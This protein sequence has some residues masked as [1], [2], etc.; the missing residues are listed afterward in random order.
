MKVIITGM[1]GTV[2]P[3]VADYFH[4]NNYQII[5]YDRTVVSTEN[6]K[7]IEAFILEHQPKFLLHFA[8][9]S[10]EWTKNLSM[11]CS[12]KQIKFVYI[13]TV[14]VFSNENRGPHTIDSIPDAED[15]YGRYK[16]MSES[17]V[18]NNHTSPYIIRLGWQI[19][20]GKGQNQ[21]IDFLYRKMAE[22]GEIKASSLWYPATSFLQDTASAI[23]Q[24][25]HELIPGLYHINSNDQYTYY[26][27]VKY[28]SKIYTE[29]I[30]VE[31]K[32]F[33]ADHRMIDERVKIR[34]LSE[35]F[36]SE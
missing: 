35:I 2:A 6:E 7:E 31:T 28:L 26:E 11:I 14:S 4:K 8:M 1:N 12:K 30:V 36:N 21:M 17:V 10:I 24:I 33:N 18:L 20:Y 5:P 22:E 25:V 9:G 3:V 29:L 32:D 27:I 23:Y 13:S 34:K 16:R 15:D 19:G